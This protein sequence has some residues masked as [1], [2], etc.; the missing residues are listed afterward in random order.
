MRTTAIV[1]ELGMMLVVFFVGALGFVT[2]LAV[3]E[4]SRDGRSAGFRSTH[5]DG[6]GIDLGDEGAQ[7]IGARDDAEDSPGVDD[8]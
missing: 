3:W 1:L 8:G 5:L 6:H 4:G 7:Q 2:L